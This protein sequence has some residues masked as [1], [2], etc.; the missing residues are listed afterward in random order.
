MSSEKQQL[1]NQQNALKSTGP[2]TAEG[3]EQSRRNALQHGMAGAGTVLTSKDA[4][5]FRK[6]IDTW[7][8]RLEPIDVVE[9]TLVA[10][11]AFANVKMRRCLQKDLPALTRRRRRAPKRSEDKQGKALG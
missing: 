3:K 6:E 2:K 4:Q 10:R 5:E 11:A 7:R 9:E 1:A 8:A